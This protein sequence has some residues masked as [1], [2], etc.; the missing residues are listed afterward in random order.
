LAEQK[1][2]AAKIVATDI[3]LNESVIIVAILITEKNKAYPIK[4][5]AANQKERPNWSSYHTI[6][7]RK[8]LPVIM[9]RIASTINLIT[10]KGI[11]KLYNYILKIIS[12]ALGSF[13]NYILFSYFKHPLIIIKIFYKKQKKGFLIFYL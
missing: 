4:K 7:L 3:Y 13:I 9:N 2:N 11:I 6:L 5:S 1:I 10:K 12:E 8:I